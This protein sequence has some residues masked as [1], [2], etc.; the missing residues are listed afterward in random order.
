MTQQFLSEFVDGGPGCS[1]DD[2]QIQVMSGSTTL[3]Y[4]PPVQNKDGTIRFA[5]NHNVVTENKRCNSCG[6]SWT[7]QKTN[8][9]GQFL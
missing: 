1:R 7:D 9:R 2:C 3:A 8:A 6:K 5:P 4:A